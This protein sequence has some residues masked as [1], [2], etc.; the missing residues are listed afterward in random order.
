MEVRLK[1]FAQFDEKVLSPLTQNRILNTEI[2]RLNKVLAE[3]EE[4]LSEL[5]I[6]FSDEAALTKR[7]NEHLALF[8]VLFAEIESLRKRV[9]DTEKEVNDVRR[10]S[11]APFRN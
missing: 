8:V 10:S 6:R 1:N 5:R 7:I 3:R 9:K 4:E 2:D 11:L